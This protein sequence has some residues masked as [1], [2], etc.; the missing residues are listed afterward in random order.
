MIDLADPEI[1]VAVQ[2]VRQAAQLAKQVQRDMITPALAKEDKSPVTVA[3]FAVQALLGH[4][5][6]Q[7]LPQHPLVAEENSDALRCAEGEP[8]LEQVTQSVGRLVP[9]ATAEKVCQWI[10]H[11]RDQPSDRFWTLDP[12]DGTKGFLRGDQYAVA[13]ALLVEGKVQ[14]GVL[15][16]PNLN[17]G[18]LV[19]AARQKGSWKAPLCSPEDFH[20]LQVADCN[21]PSQARVLRSFESDHTNVGQLDQLM[22][23]LGVQAEPVL[24]DSQA[25]YA[26]LAEGK[27]DLLFR[28]LSPQQPQYQE[29]IWDQAA[30]SLVVEEA[31]GQIS[32]LEGK[33]LDF[34]TGRTLLHNRG[35]V[36]SNSHLHE[37]A[38]K[39]L[40]NQGND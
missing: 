40:A 24:M 2:V 30:G 38:L 20:Q 16:C 35:V 36:A 27:G 8:I 9:G 39:A 23:A 32:D 7:A 31:G 34:S 11:G 33:P 4:S 3:D 10:D 12:I 19:V 21:D 22:Q 14:I 15:G 29:R 18:I 1:G 25:K 6:K 17:G 5:L 37:A 13:L 26:L 28:L